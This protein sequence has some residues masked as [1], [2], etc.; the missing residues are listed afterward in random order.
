MPRE[1]IS[2]GARSSGVA[3]NLL[4]C[5]LR[6]MTEGSAMAVGENEPMV[7]ASVGQPV[8]RYLPAHLSALYCSMTSPDGG[9]RNDVE[10]RG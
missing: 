4:F 6:L 2:A 3:P 10:R 9:G 8:V 1:S 5:W 7:G